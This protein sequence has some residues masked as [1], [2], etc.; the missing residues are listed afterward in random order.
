MRVRACDS[1]RVIVSCIEIVNR[2]LVIASEG[3]SCGTM[4][5][6][7]SIELKEHSENNSLILNSSL[8]G[9]KRFISS[10]FI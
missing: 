4:E 10:S 8:K 9:P 5:S 6:C 3:I 7:L 1:L 2:F